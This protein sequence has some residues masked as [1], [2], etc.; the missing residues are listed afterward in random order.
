[1]KSITSTSISKISEHFKERVSLFSDGID[2]VHIHD[3]IVPE[4]VDQKKKNLVKKVTTSK[5]IKF[6]RDKDAHDK[7][8]DW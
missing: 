8:D 7:D 6:I 2:E 1:M 4:L 3:A 5:D